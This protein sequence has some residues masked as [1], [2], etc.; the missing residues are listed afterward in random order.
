MVQWLRLHALNA[1][2]LD[3]IPGLGINIPQAM[4]QKKKK[5]KENK[6]THFTIKTAKEMKNEI[7]KWRKGGKEREEGNIKNLMFP[8]VF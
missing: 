4:K 3:S 7:K 6:Q 8:K 1:E 2:G 5:G